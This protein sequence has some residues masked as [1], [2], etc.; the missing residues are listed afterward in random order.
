M[1]R[2]LSS[3]WARRAVTQAH[4]A[5]S[6]ARAALVLAGAPAGTPPPVLPAVA[7]AEG[8]PDERSVADREECLQRVVRRCMPV[9][10]YKPKRT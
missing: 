3:I 2:E 5:P 6:F 7:V 1:W 4:I 9:V 8:V 10:S